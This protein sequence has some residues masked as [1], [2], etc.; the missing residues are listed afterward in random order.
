ME[1]ED[2]RI[3]KKR[4][5]LYV[6]MTTPFS[7]TLRFIEAKLY[8]VSGIKKK[9]LKFSFT[10]FEVM[11]TAPYYM[12]FMNMGRFSSLSEQTHFGYSL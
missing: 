6:K 1:K 8:Q 7:K 3:G 2:T 9:Q 5:K 12:N 4:D 11:W 10:L